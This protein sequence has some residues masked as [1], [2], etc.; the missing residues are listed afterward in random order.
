MTSIWGMPCPSLQRY[1]SPIAK[2]YRAKHRCFDLI[3]HSKVPCAV[4]V[5][6]PNRWSRGERGNSVKIDSI[7]LPPGPAHDF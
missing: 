1:P 4:A 5:L 6:R 3:C 2:L 7:C